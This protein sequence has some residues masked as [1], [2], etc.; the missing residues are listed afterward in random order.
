MGGGTSHTQKDA[1]ILAALLED[2]ENL[3]TDMITSEQ[4]LHSRTRVYPRTTTAA[5][6]TNITD[7]GVNTFGAWTNIIPVGAV[8]MPYHL[9][10]YKPIVAPADT[11]TIQFA[12]SATPTAA[13]MLGEDV[14]EAGA[15]FFPIPPLLICSRDMPARTGIW[16][17]IMSR[18]GGRTVQVSLTLNRA[19]T[20]VGEEYRPAPWPTWP[21]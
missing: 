16:A 12:R 7:G 19:Y 5:S 2:Y 6:Y 8:T 15:A 20:Y 14:F 13:Q 3:L 9:H 1:A 21:W 10:G 17:R 18:V 11:Y 4:N